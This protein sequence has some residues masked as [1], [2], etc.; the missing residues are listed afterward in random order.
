LIV[1]RLIGVLEDIRDVYR[2]K[3]LKMPMGYNG[4]FLEMEVKVC[5]EFI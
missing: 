2:K 1:K 5:R 4:L 3:C